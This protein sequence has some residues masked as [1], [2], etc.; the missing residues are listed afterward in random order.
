[1]RFEQILQDLK[2]KVYR[3]IYLLMGEEAFFI[4]K[5]SEYIENN[6]L[7]ESEK[8]FNQQIVYGLETDIITLIAEA[9]RFPM[10][11]S[12]NVI[13]IK[14][15]QN[16]KKIEELA[17][18][19]EQPLSSTL[20][21]IC[22][23]YGKVDKRK[24]VVKAIAK[25][26]VV[27]ESKKL[28]DNQIPPWIDNYVSHHKFKISPKVALQLAEFLGNDLSKIANEIDKLSI[29]MN[30]GDEITSALVE[31]NI[32]LSKEYNYFELNAALGTK[33]V[34][35]SNQIIHYFSSNEKKYPFPVIIGS[36][37][38]YFSQLLNY[39]FLKDKSRNA[40]AAALKV[41]PFF[42]KD[43]E[44]AAKQYTIKKV[45]AIIAYLREYD[46]KSKGVDN[47][48]SENSE[49]LRELVFKILH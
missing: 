7:D 28:Y 15:A 26:G 4:D 49:L 46:V 1:M 19:A 25:H 6:I 48:G 29:N 40:A 31:Q 32:G 5:L 45:V 13:I 47:A 16:L 10:M 44:I 37:Y 34:L 33:N 42:M 30:T 22:Y 27:F 24:A 2:N 35:K 20:L 23:K 8:E 18:Y 41:H 3:P 21:V 9:K 38:R 43:Y 39:H 14:E 36:L 12:H 11:A 17:S